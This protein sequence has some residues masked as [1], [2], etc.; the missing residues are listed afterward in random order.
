MNNDIF[1]NLPV[2]DLPEVISDNLRDHGF[3]YQHSFQD[4]DS[5][6]WELV[7]MTPGAA[8]QS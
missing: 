2:A 6:M 4:P 5:H 7:Y 1:I 8:L 3:M